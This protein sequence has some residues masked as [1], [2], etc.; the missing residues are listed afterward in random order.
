[1]LHI[2][3]ENN[4]LKNRTFPLP[5]GVRKILQNTLVNYKGDKTVDG[6]KRL[7]NILNMQTISYHELKRIKNFFDHY[8]GSDKSAE[9]ILNGGEPMK[10]WVNNTLYTA[11]KAV[12]DFKQAKKDAGV[13]NAFI[14]SH[15]KNRQNKK[16]NKPTQVK[17][18]T[19]NVN[20]NMLNATSMKYENIIRESV[21]IE[22][23]YYDYGAEYVLNSFLKSGKGTKQNWG[24]LINPS[25]YQKALSE[26]VTHNQLIKF[27]TKYIYQWM[28]IIMRNTCILEANT[29]LAG[30]SSSFPYEEIE[31]FAMSYLGDNFYDLDYNKLYIKISEKEFLSLCAE[32]Q[33]YLNESN[34]IHKDG[35]YDLFMNQEEVD[36]YDLQMERLKNKDKFQQY[37]KMAEEY[38]SK[39]INKYGI[40]TDKI[41]VNVNNQVIYRIQEIGKFLNEIGLYDWMKMPDGSEAW[42][43][44]GLKPI[45]SL[46]RQYDDSKT[47]EETLVLINKILDV[48]HQRGDLSSIF[49]TGG[50]KSLSQISGTVSENKHMTIV[51]SES[52]EN[53][54][55]E[56]A[57]DKFSL[58]ELSSIPSFSGRF[59]YCTQHLG[60]HIG[61]GS[62]RATF[63][64]DDEKVLKL[65]WNNKGLSQNIEER[66]TYNAPIFPNVYDYDE[67]GKWIISEFVLPAKSQDF[68]H[69]FDLTFEQFVS[70]ILSCDE[71]RFNRR[72]FRMGMPEDE[73]LSLLEKYDELS[74]FDEYIGDYGNHR[75]SPVGDMVR[76]AN[77][78]LTQRD[79]EATIVL[80]DSGLTEDVWNTHYK[81]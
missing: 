77:Y 59:N 56:A 60:E 76:I 81:R 3:A 57:D 49:I 54:L 26:F 68:K 72:Y 16:K 61:K 27:P 32:K 33:I 71:Y 14:K 70:F 21:D 52:Q 40:T 44:Y 18:N 12:R 17:F 11:T 64:I 23:Y 22:E 4:E 63:Q 5:D 78:G 34:G 37:K 2:I 10:T 58:E 36:E 46:I 25:M 15:S 42:S 20:K 51:I 6:Y 29:Q 75:F 1:M 62:S 13:D 80:L 69:C 47:P 9:F 67:D 28:G 50:A 66:R 39:S 35:Q 65:A 19:D 74:E 30:H 24:T 41:D 73:W 53:L 45:F 38:T 7:N 8:S 55:K 43:D 79:G 31:D 48:Y